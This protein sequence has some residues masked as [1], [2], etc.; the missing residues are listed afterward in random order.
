MVD[1]SSEEEDE[2][3]K[4]NEDHEITEQAQLGKY[5]DKK[6]NKKDGDLNI[7]D[8][9]FDIYLFS[10]QHCKQNLM[11]YY[12]QISIFVAIFTHKLP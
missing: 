1:S 7:D 5:E 10:S 12:L 11:K 4:A 3:E 9:W 6:H 2:E 8:I